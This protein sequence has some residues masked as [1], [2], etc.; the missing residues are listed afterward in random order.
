MIVSIRHKGLRQYYGEGRS[1][2]LPAAQLSKIRRILDMLDA[3]TCEDDIKALGM[4]THLLRG[5]Y[6]GFWAVSITG[7]YRIIF[8]FQDGDIHDVDYLDYH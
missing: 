5:N 1:P 3:V 8:R 4:N 7:N 6:E 2:K